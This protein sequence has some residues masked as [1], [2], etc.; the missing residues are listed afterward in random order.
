MAAMFIGM[1]SAYIGSYVGGFI[2][3]N[4]RFAF[5]GSWTPLAVVAAAALAMAVFTY[6]SEKKGKEWLDN[7][8]I[9]GSMLVGMLAAVLIGR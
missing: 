8:S 3:G 5:A 1:V 6:F 2:S 9:A 7:F 4:G